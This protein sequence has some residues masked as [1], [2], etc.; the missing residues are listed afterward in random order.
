MNTIPDLLQN[1]VHDNSKKTAVISNE[2]EYSYKEIDDL[3]S[4]VS[5]NILQ[6]PRNSVVSLMLENSLEFIVSYLGILK[7][8][9]IAHIIP[10]N[11]SKE[12]LT[13]Q[14]K[15]ANT[16]CLISSK[17]YASKLN[18]ELINFDVLEANEILSK[19]KVKAIDNYSNP[20]DFAYL[21]YTSGT[22]SKPKGIGI[23]HKKS[24]FTTNNIVNILGYKNSDIEVLPLSLSHSFGLGC[25]HTALFV[26]ST[27][28][29]H[30][31]AIDVENVLNSITCYHATTLAAVPATLTK[32]VEN[33]NNQ[34]KLTCENLRLIIT[35]STAI[36][37]LTVKKLKNI[38]KTGKL[39]T[40]YGL[41]EASRST[42]MVFNDITGKE[43]SVGKPAQNVKIKI[44]NEMDDP[45]KNGEIFI[46]GENVIEKYWKNEEMDHNIQ[47]GWIKTS[48]MGH[49]DEDGYLY[50]TGRVDDMINVGGEKVFPNQIESVV[51]RLD[52]IDEAVVIGI[53]HDTFGEVAK[54]FVKK[55]QDSKIKESD[56]IEH[57]IKNLERYKV[58]TSIRFIEDFPQ[59]EYG[60]IKR[61]A[62]KDY[63]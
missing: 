60:K 38:I 16:T 58:P 27:I 46:K 3:S 13:E 21:I 50:L 63:K 23:T 36:P 15:S 39:A 45:K 9:K 5:T 32:M 20:D 22:T 1:S 54:L 59:T 17:G 41:T 62:L 49:F 4:S 28:I 19:H 7:V 33:F 6:Y 29:L 30:K 11:I 40:Y 43:A 10:P 44:V 14:I 12:N 31:N 35:N 56:I 61:Y 42:F 8:G 51:K 18:S 34:T 52:G 55:S 26:G 57:C 37:E 53:S 47:N 2:E 24:L 48:D 25:L